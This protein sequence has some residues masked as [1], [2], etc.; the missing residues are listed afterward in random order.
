[1]LVNWYGKR[2]SSSRNN[3]NKSKKTTKFCQFHLTLSQKS[4]CSSVND[5]VTTCACVMVMHD[6]SCMCKISPGSEWILLFEQKNE[7]SNISRAKLSVQIGST[8]AVTA[9]LGTQNIHRP[10]SFFTVWCGS[11]LWWWYWILLLHGA[12]QTFCATATQII[13]FFLCA[14]YL[15]SM[16]PHSCHNTIHHIHDHH[17]KY[18]E[19]QVNKQWNFL[20][21][22][23]PC[24]LSYSV[25]L[26]YFIF[27]FLLTFFFFWW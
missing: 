21:H 22:S 18:M 7:E 1:M 23:L 13:H 19:S 14:R 4:E 16:L 8:E 15:P 20:S 24:W 11:G 6:N 3:K 9:K 25:F 26:F 17:I 10:K 12:I 2:T 5:R 27:H